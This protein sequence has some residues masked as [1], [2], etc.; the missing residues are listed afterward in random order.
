MSERWS[1]SGDGGGGEG[2]G[3]GLEA[4]LQ[5]LSRKASPAGTGALRGL[6][7]RVGRKQIYFNNAFA[8]SVIFMF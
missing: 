8:S 5:L 1:Q 7:R 4:R 6:S 3:G 2:L